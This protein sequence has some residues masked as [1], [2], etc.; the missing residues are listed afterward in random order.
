MS[1]SDWKL[2]WLEMVNWWFHQPFEAYLGLIEDRKDLFSSRL[3]QKICPACIATAKNLILLLIADQ[4]WWTFGLIL[5]WRNVGRQSSSMNA[6]VLASLSGE[7]EESDFMRR[8][9]R[10]FIRIHWRWI[11]SPCQIQRLM[12]YLVAGN[13]ILG[14][15]YHQ[16]LCQPNVFVLST[17]LCSSQQKHIVSPAIALRSSCICLEFFW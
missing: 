17:V 15:F 4:S 13:G 8:R 2:N 1:I 3:D 12:I 11:P 16:E 10:F 6:C 9:I 7:A 14:S 5:K